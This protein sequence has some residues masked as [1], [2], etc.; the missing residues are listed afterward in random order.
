MVLAVTESLTLEATVDLP[1]RNIILIASDRDFEVSFVGK[2]IGAN[3]TQIRDSEVTL[4]HFSDP[5]SRLL[6]LEVDGE[7]DTTGDDSDLFAGNG[8]FTK[9]C[10]DVKGAKLR[11]D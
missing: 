7:F 4:K 3:R 6:T 8:E 10:G 9:L 11:H 2:T 1:L 5:A